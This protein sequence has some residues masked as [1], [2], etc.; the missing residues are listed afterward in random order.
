MK[1]G[2]KTL[3]LALLIYF[4]GGTVFDG[5]ETSSQEFDAGATES[6]N[7]FTIA[8]YNLESVDLTDLETIRATADILSRFD[9]IALQCIRSDDAE[10]VL[11]SLVEELNRYGYHYEYLLGPFVKD[12]SNRYAFIHRPD[13]MRPVEWHSYDDS[14]ENNFGIKP[15]FARFETHDATFDFTLINYYAEL[16]SKLQE[17]D[18]LP[19]VID[20]VKVRFPEETDI[21]ILCSAKTDYDTLSVSDPFK[22]LEQKDYILL[23]NAETNQGKK[24]IDDPIDSQIIVAAASEEMFWEDAGLLAIDSESIDEQDTDAVLWSRQPGFSSIIIVNNVP[25]NAEDMNNGA[26]SKAFCFFGTT[27]N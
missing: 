11:D 20:D 7:R 10:S 13:I 18:L 8:S 2:Y 21:I 27:S 5:T 3:L 14:K 26:N 16:E 4:F 19:L 6:Q 24:N 15:F 12:G 22:S 1:P 9:I 23:L 25:E 17:I